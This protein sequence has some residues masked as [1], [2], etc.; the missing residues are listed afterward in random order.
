MK[1]KIRY[2][3]ELQKTYMI[4]AGCEK[5]LLENYSGRMALQG[6]LKGLA[7]CHKHYIDGEWEIW[8]DITSLQ[9]M[10]QLFAVKEIAFQELKYFIEQLLL[11]LE[12][13]EKCLMDSRQLCLEPQLL[14]V[15]MEKEQVRFLYDHTEKR[16]S[17]GICELAEYLLGRTCHEDEQAVRLVYYFYEQVQKE[18]FSVHDMEAYLHENAASTAAEQ[19]STQRSTGRVGAGGMQHSAGRADASSVQHSTGGAGTDG[20]QRSTGRAEAGGV[21]DDFWE[22]VQWESVPK[23]QTRQARGHKSKKTSQNTETDKKRRIQIDWNSKGGMLLEG[24]LACTIM[25][26]LLVIGF[27]VIQRYF[28]L[29]QWERLLWIGV[30]VLLFIIGMA[31]AA[32][33]LFWEWQPEQE[34]GQR[35]GLWQKQ[36]RGQRQGLWQK[37]GCGER[38][39]S[40]WKQGHGERGQAEQG[41]ID[42]DWQEDFYRDLE[43]AAQPQE[44]D[45]RTIYVGNA[46][47][48][49]EHCLIEKQKG[50]EKKYSITAYPFVIGKEK[51]RVNLVLRD[52][53]ISRIHARLIEEDGNIYLEDLHSTNGTFL[54][55]FPLTP[56]ERIKLKRGDLIQ[57]G[58]VELDFR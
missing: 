30:S 50:E 35:K 37:Q 29:T 48:N 10:E 56:H 4:A 13:M 39:E 28:E 45:G 24:G 47:L 46:L 11:M 36:E 9:T 7:A 18:N 38:Q 40:G 55:D 32:I 27:F 3:R 12:E 58:R 53:S 21:Q 33:G 20:T 5:E 25:V 41:N 26:V 42:S 52:H 31:M 34:R 8:Y 15:D 43:E 23:P 49:R 54:N 57:L 22:A 19:N 2:Q 6:K 17:N 44:S 14:Y 51:G 1:G 16:E